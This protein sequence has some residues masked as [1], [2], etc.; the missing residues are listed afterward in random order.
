MEIK[1]MIYILAVI[2]EHFL[3]QLPGCNYI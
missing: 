2:R 1:P 3:Y